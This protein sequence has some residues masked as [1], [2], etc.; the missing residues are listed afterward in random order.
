MIQLQ[1]VILS[2][3][4]KHLRLIIP[5]FLI[6]L[7]YSIFSAVTPYISKAQID[8]LSTQDQSIYFWLAIPFLLATSRQSV[9]S[10]LED[11]F[12]TTFSDRARLDTQQLVINK[13]KQLD[14]G[15]FANRASRR[16]V[17]MALASE[18]V[19]GRIFNLVG[20]GSNI[21]ILTLASIPMFSTVGWRVSLIIVVSIVISGLL[22]LYE[23]KR[24]VLRQ[25]V[26]D[27]IKDKIWRIESLYIYSF[28]E[29]F[30]LGANRQMEKK[31][32]D[33]FSQSEKINQDEIAQRHQISSFDSILRELARLVITALVAKSVLHDGMT[34]GNFTLVIAY[35]S[36]IGSAF[37]DLINL[38]SDYLEASINIDQLN[39]FLN[40]TQHLKFVE[41][42]TKVTKPI[43]LIKVNNAHFTYRSFGTDEKQYY[44]KLADRFKNYLKLVGSRNRSSWQI[45]QFIKSFELAEQ[46][47]K[48]LNGVDFQ[49]KAG[50][51]VALIGRNGAG[52]TTITNLLLHQYQLDSGEI[53][54]DGKPIENFERESLISQFGVLHQN[55]L[56]FHGMSIRD[57]LLLGV[58]K[59]TSDRKI[60]ACLKRVGLADR[61]NDLPKGLDTIWGEETNFSGGQAQLFAIARVI[62]QERPFVIFDEGMSNLDAEKEF[63]I[64]DILRLEF[65]KSGIILITHRLSVA[66]HADRIIVLDDGKI[67]QEGTH[68]QLIQKTGFYQNFWNLQV[69]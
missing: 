22:N 19:F 32:L 12:R 67:I 1:T 48:V 54:I 57:N 30:T 59:P 7:I 4:H 5:L 61:I 6:S 53:L 34:I 43:S 2:I 62:L 29:M 44:L 23:Q 14:L 38:V 42:P 52:K 8:A 51:M 33:V 46:T 49:V 45:D 41:N 9:L 20:R 56:N 16:L 55:P 60:I 40:L 10:F 68:K 66:R 36:Q 37:G 18:R 47:T 50:E 58:N 25:A 31:F 35:T 27:R 69:N 28:D 13:L 65:S 21:V 64:V 17:Q 39:F 63:Q 11:K 15:F 3:F 24:E 26:N